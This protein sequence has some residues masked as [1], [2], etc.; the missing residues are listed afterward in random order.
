M[1]VETTKVR[2]FSAICFAVPL[3]AMIAVGFAWGVDGISQPKAEKN[4]VTEVDSKKR[5][6]FC[7]HSHTWGG[8]GTRGVDNCEGSDL[9]SQSVTGDS[10]C[11]HTHKFKLDSTTPV[12][13][14]LS[15]LEWCDNNME[16]TSFP[17]SNIYLKHYH[18]NAGTGTTGP[19]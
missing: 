12:A 10:F 16:A 18:N 11:S 4:A 6:T 19:K 1:H 3:V 14:D 8:R 13:G 15:V 5:D 17:P 9:S 7:R 2:L